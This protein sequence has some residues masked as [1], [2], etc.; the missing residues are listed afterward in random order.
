MNAEFQIKSIYSVLPT[1]SWD[2]GV[3]TTSAVS[4]TSICAEC[5]CLGKHDLKWKWNERD[6]AETE[7]TTWLT[8]ASGSQYEKVWIEC[9]GKYGLRWSWEQRDSGCFQKHDMAWKWANLEQSVATWENT[10]PN[11]QYEKKWKFEPGSNENEL[12]TWTS[13]A[14]GAPWEKQWKELPVYTGYAPHVNISINSSTSNSNIAFSAAAIRSVDF[15]DSYNS[16]NNIV[17][18]EGYNPAVFCH[19]YVMPGTYLVKFNQTEYVTVNNFRKQKCLGKHER[20]WKWNLYKSDCF[21]K[22]YLFWNWNAL[23]NPTLSGT[24][25]TW[26]SSAEYQDLQKKW[27]F[28]PTE[29]QL[30]WFKTATNQSLNKKWKE[31]LSVYDVI[32]EKGLFYKQFGSDVL[33]EQDVNENSVLKDLTWQWQ[34]IVQEGTHDLNREVTWEDVAL[35]GKEQ[36]TWDSISTP[37]IPFDSE[38]GEIYWKW[39]SLT[40]IYYSGDPH[41]KTITWENTN[42]DHFLTK[43]G[44]TLARRYFLSC[45]QIPILMQESF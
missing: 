3:P 27:K 5:E 13:T 24:Y 9:S 15:G 11:E 30:M 6:S 38:R 10:K 31:D 43:R 28:E 22:H 45:Q 37:C 40:D 35:L 39:K 44:T 23:Q 16:E 32:T 14:T 26:Q 21:Q 25:A 7:Q 18:T 29:E 17:T 12:T 4:L 8:T 41:N 42:K 19:T 2:L 34:N 1:Y 36:N 33:Y 20:N